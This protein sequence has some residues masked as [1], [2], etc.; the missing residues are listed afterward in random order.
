MSSTVNW[1]VCVL[2]YMV[3]WPPF[4]LPSLVTPN[5][6]E[7]TRFPSSE[8]LQSRTSTMS[9]RQHILQVPKVVL[10]LRIVQ[11]ATAV[12]IL[13][14]AAYGITYLSFDGDDLILFTVNSLKP[15]IVTDYD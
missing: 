7:Y 3:K 4:L 6:I 1:R 2:L 14:L 11:L 5:S 12:A 8:Y 13:G 10:G 9:D 15:Q